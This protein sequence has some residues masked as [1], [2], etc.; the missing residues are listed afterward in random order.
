MRVSVMLHLPALVLTRHIEKVFRSLHKMSLAVRGLYGEGS[1]AMG[2]FYQIS[3]QVTLGRSETELI[4]EVNVAVAVLI[5]Y[6]R[7]ARTFLIDETRNDLHDRVSRAYGILCNAKTITSEETMQLLV[8]RADGREPGPHQES[9]D[10]HR[11]PA[12]HSHAT[13]SFADDPR[14]AHEFG[15]S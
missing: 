7:R 6:E 14:H 2:D 9:G 13:G 4:E 1:Q 5:D 3:N 15:R 12:V 8:E 10:P 11:Q